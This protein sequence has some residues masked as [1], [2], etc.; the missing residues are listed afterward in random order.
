MKT[1]NVTTV[2]SICDVSNT[3]RSSDA[4]QN[5]NIGSLNIIGSG[6]HYMEPM[7][8]GGGPLGP[9]QE[10]P[11][12]QNTSSPSNAPNTCFENFCTPLPPLS[13]LLPRLLG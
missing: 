13:A 3:A 7:V 8:G 2:P 12:H 10:G 5:P 6:G 1:G 4:L 9:S 11:Q